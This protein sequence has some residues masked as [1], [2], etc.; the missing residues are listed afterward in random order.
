MSERSSVRPRPRAALRRELV[1][2]LLL[3]LAALVVLKLVFFPARTP[4]AA[5]ARGVAERIAQPAPVTGSTHK[6]NP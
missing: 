2:A 1:L 5:A 3:K 6:E 4:A